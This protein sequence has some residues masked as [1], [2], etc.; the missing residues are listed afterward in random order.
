MSDRIGYRVAHWRSRRELTQEQLGE[1]IGKSQPFVSMIERGQ[2][3]I[4]SRRLLID[5]AHAL[6]VST[7]DLTGQPREPRSNDDM[8]IWSAVPLLRG[9]LDDDPD[10]P[11]PVDMDRLAAQ[12]D[13][14]ARARMM[15]DY[16]TLAKL[17]P[18][19]VADTRRLATDSDDEQAYGLFVRAATTAALTIK[20]F[21][22]VDLAARLAERAEHAAAVTGDP[23]DDAVAAFAAAQVALASGTP[24]G[25]GR[26][27][28]VAAAAADRLAGVESDAVLEMRTMLHLHAAL[29]AAARHRDN[30]VSAH[31][32]EA[33][34]VVG[35]VRSDLLRME[36]TVANVRTWRVGIAVENGEPDRAPEY[37]RR[38]DRAQLRT[39]QRQARLHLDTGRGWWAA[40]DTE[41]AVRSLLAADE[42]APT[43]IRGRSVVREI[44][45]QAARDSGRAGVPGLVELA[46]RVGVDPANPDGEPGV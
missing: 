37:A 24:G 13:E 35:R 20:P 1:R 34:T 39:P 15:C 42:V 6:G 30:E 23:V 10:N 19:V 45:A 31:Y 9:A 26:S 14:A 8:A 38:V 46:S 12:V 22:E 36:A 2:R 25:P 32:A 44:V 18:R 41:R 29:S 11:E 40:G 21:G 27:Y 16:P 3:A 43:E 4:D 28:T 5:L 7:N 33:E 17:L